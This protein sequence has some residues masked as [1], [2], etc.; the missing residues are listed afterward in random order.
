MINFIKHNLS[1]IITTWT[2]GKISFFVLLGLLICKAYLGINWL[3]L[4]ILLLTSMLSGF[5]FYNVKL[6]KNILLRFLQ[7]FIIYLIIFSLSSILLTIIVVGFDY[8]LVNF[9][10]CSSNDEGIE[11]KSTTGKETVSS[12]ND[13]NKISSTASQKEEE[14]YKIPK[15]PVDKT[16]E[17]IGK[18]VKSAIEEVIPNIGS[19]AAGGTVGGVALK[20]SQG[21]PAG[22]RLLFVAGSS[23]AG[24]G[25]TYAGISGAKAIGKRLEID[26]LI[27]DSKH[28]DTNVE[29]IPSP[30]D[31][32]FLESPLENWELDGNP[33]EVIISSIL[34]L[35]V[36][37]LLLLIMLLYLIISR[38]AFTW[39]SNNKEYFLLILLKK[40]KV[41]KEREEWIRNLIE[42]INKVN[43]YNNIYMSFFIFIITA[44]LFIFLILS[45]YFISD[46]KYNLESYIEVYN[47]VNVDKSP[48]ISTSST[49]SLVAGK[50]RSIFLI[51][52][53]SRKTIGSRQSQVDYVRLYSSGS[54]SGSPFEA[55][56]SKETVAT[57]QTV[58]TKQTIVKQTIGGLSVPSQVSLNENVIEEL[59]REGILIVKNL[60]EYLTLINEL[61]PLYTNDSQNL[62]VKNQLSEIFKSFLH[63]Y[64][65]S[66]IDSKDLLI[67]HDKY[68]VR[69]K[70]IKKGS[71]A[72]SKIYV[73]DE[74]LKYDY[75]YVWE[76]LNKY[77]KYIL[78]NKFTPLK[79]K[80]MSNFIQSSIKLLDINSKYED[81]IIS[82]ADS[83]DKDMIDILNVTKKT[84]GGRKN[85]NRLKS[86]TSTDYMKLISCKLLEYSVEID[87]K[88]LYEIQINLAKDIPIKSSKIKEELEEKINNLIKI[89]EQIQEV[90]SFY[91]NKLDYE[92]DSMQNVA[93]RHKLLM[94][95]KLPQ[96]L[97]RVDT[98]NIEKLKDLQK[99][100][101]NYNQF[102]KDL[103]CKSSLSRE[104]KYADEGLLYSIKNILSLNNL[105]LEDKQLSI[106]RL[107][108]SNDQNWFERELLTM[109]DSTS[110]SYSVESIM[111][112]DLYK[113]TINNLTII[114]NKFINNNFRRLKKGLLN[115][116]NDA[117]AALIMISLG[118][119]LVLNLGF[120]EAIKSIMKVYEKGANQTQL[121]SSVGNS[122]I[123][124]MKWMYFEGSIIK[125][126][127][128]SVMEKNNILK[129]R[130]LEE[131][132]NIFIKNIES[133]DEIENSNVLIPFSIG[134]TIVSLLLSKDKVFKRNI[135]MVDN[136]ISEVLIT[137]NPKY[138]HK[139][140]I[141]I[142]SSTHLPMLVRPNLPDN[143]GNNYLPY[144][145]G[146]VSHVMNT[147]DRLVKD[148]Y[149]NKYPTENLKGLVKTMVSLNNVPFKINKIAYSIFIK[150]W[151]K[152]DSFLFKGY[153]KK[154]D[155]EDMDS[156]IVKIEKRA[157][158]SIYWQYLNILQIAGLY[159]NYKFYLPTFADFRGRIYCFSPYLSYQGN[160]LAR[161]LLLFDEGSNNLTIEGLTYMKVYFSN[162]AGQD[163]ES[164][165][166][167]IIW[168]NNNLSQIYSK[169]LSSKLCQV[170]SL[171][172]IRDL[173]E[174]F[175][176][177][178]ILLALGKYMLEEREG[179]KFKS[180]INNPILFD[181]SCNG[182]QHLASMTRDIELARKTNVL[183]P[184]LP[185]PAGQSSDR[186]A[187]QEHMNTDIEA[188][189]P[190]DLYSY[191]AELVQKNL[192]LEG[193]Y[194]HIKI[195]R[196]FVK[197]SVMTI[198]YN[199]SLIGVQ[200]QIREHTKYIKELNKHIYLLPSEFSKEDKIIHLTLGEVNKLGTIVYK[201]L[202]QDI[203]S[204]K[205]LKD[206]LDGMVN[207]LLK[208]GL[209]IYW[210]TPNGLKV[211]LSTVKF[212][213]YVLKS[214]LYSGN[215]PITI[216][217]PSKQLD[218]MAIKRSLM[219][220]LIHSL[221]ASNIQLFV[222]KLDKQI[223]FYTIHD[224]FA[225]LPN[226]MKYLE[227]KVK[228]AF[229][230]IYFKDIN[231]V[232]T[233]HQQ[234]I[235]QIK[236]AAKVDTDYYGQEY[237]TILT[238]KNEAKRIYIPQLPNAFTSEKL[239]QYFIDGLQNS[240]YFIG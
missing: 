139:M 137:L 13:N 17:I 90:R 233:L 42:R 131:F 65:I 35:N 228:E 176:F 99:D 166:N 100:L 155:I 227:F 202:N 9:I 167:K 132:S 82:L 223:P 62:E 182:I 179:K 201:V 174:P 2:R 158:N 181:A 164:W 234:L 30:T 204:L 212:E 154:L 29:K 47:Y 229:I 70:A 120:T 150:E 238:D 102:M 163:K 57:K 61:L 222:N 49:A 162:L 210:L 231:Y 108:L 85:P 51:Y 75:P 87:S 209:W 230:E 220:N 16:L 146:E 221:D 26:T 136:N 126:N 156:S 203:P 80:H 19:A 92:R 193:V 196:K 10:E 36:S 58:D 123:C 171:L 188:A 88:I 225:S 113:S 89:R 138:E 128:I 147:Y 79:D 106:E 21:L 178:A 208:L 60:N 97:G 55:A 184:A 109:K 122:I 64:K 213:S 95:Q 200:N 86:L 63:Y 66:G 28:S 32:L 6:S 119:N 159:L 12:N 141:S 189:P 53:F 235:L 52:C 59:D 25:G 45:I 116:D 170:E 114:L 78:K 69:I 180:S 8:L 39:I 115:K 121:I 7:T 31:D 165:N 216:T 145:S 226:N 71:E 142:M 129:G 68:R 185:P 38:S 40:F 24:A 148:N 72:R 103:E 127:I 98:V 15:K 1:S 4:V 81:F 239:K 23:A 105:S 149:K 172:I 50:A 94:E 91:L 157:H 48:P 101:D 207:I 110:P 194:T 67:K 46:L 37:V 198:P 84:A 107:C 5:I 125:N 41:R 11:I 206:Y 205:L 173:K 186:F 27:K 161:A 175:Q 187:S 219:P 112:H 44:L 96:S 192:P 168:A 77:N 191:A 224:C 237:I 217:L 169:L 124:Q 43:I 74:N 140:N 144:L 199:I 104:A 183:S 14:Y 56:W 177:I 93:A 133:L 218:K 73:F 54:G 33:L 134:Q 236:S 18:G 22:Q 211:N 34:S 117:Y 190:E 151:N 83:V 160:D 143:D 135:T 215:R 76:V 232:V 3:S 152:A 195:T 20:M 130:K 197:K 111:L 153:N 240:R 214:R 118:P